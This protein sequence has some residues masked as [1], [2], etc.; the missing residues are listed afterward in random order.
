MLS[1]LSLQLYH[2]GFAFFRFRAHLS[3]YP[4][5]FSIILSYVTHGINNSIF[6]CPSLQCVRR[7]FEERESVHAYNGLRYFTTIVAVLIRTAFE[8]RKKIVWK[9]LALLSSAV[10]AIANTYWDIVVDWGLLQRQSKKIF[11]RDKLII[12]HK[13]VYFV[14]MVNITRTHTFFSPSSYLLIH[15][16]FDSLHTG[17]GY[18]SEIRLAAACLDSWRAFATWENGVNNIF[19]PRNSA[20]RVMELLQV[21]VATLVVVGYAE[22]RGN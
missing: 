4:T 20:A 2:T 1:I 3:L 19:M 10:A 13:K 8:F 17:C 21:N 12:P 7:L 6:I 14:A 22:W 16:F 18:F 11:L 15:I 5:L 9:V